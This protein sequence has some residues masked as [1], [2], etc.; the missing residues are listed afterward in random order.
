[1]NADVSVPQNQTT[2]A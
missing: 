1:V 2:V